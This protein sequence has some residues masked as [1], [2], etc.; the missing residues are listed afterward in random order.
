MLTGVNKAFTG[1]I[2]L[3]AGLV[4]M[5][6]KKDMPS[7]DPAPTPAPAASPNI[8]DSIVG[9]Y[10]GT[11]HVTTSSSWHYAPATVTDTTYTLHAT[12]TKTSADSFSTGV[13]TV[14]PTGNLLFDTSGVYTYNNY[15]TFDTLTIY[16]ANDSIYYVYH[17][18][19]AVDG[20]NTYYSNTIK[21]FGGKK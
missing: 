16:P 2:F 5:G 19:F 21:R 9:T 1:I 12:L 18:S 11:M 3:L 20:G 17:Y 13:L 4:Y 6:C 8:V 10:S 14:N 7:P 15:G